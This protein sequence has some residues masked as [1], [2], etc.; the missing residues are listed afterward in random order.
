[1]TITL[2]KTFKEDLQSSLPDI[3]R[4]YIRVPITIILTPV[5]FVLMI[6]TGITQGFIGTF[7]E[8]LI[9]CLK[10][11]GRSYFVITENSNESSRN[12]KV[13]EASDIEVKKSR[14]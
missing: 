11:P 8:F 5:V 13:D 4:H 10:G 1:M 14:E 12:G 6:L 7:K 9:P 3:Q 2:S